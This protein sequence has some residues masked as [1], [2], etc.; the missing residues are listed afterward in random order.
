MP[1]KQIL[2]QDK[3]VSILQNA[4][5][6]QRIPH[7][8]IFAGNDGIGKF[9]TA[10]QW[11][12][13]LLCE[14][15]VLENGFYDCCSTCKS[16]Q[17]VDADSHPDFIHIYKELLEFT[18]EGKNR[19]PPLELP[20]DVIREFLVQ[21]APKKPFHSK[22]KI[23]V[24]TEAEKLN[25]SSQN[26]L[27]K[28]L[29][30]PPGYCSII[31]I[32]NALDKL[33]PTTKSRCQTIRFG[34]VDRSVIADKLKNFDLDTETSDFFARFSKGS[35]GTALFLAKLQAAGAEI[36]N[37]KRQIIETVASLKLEFA[38]K[39][40]S[41]FLLVAKK[42]AKSWSKISTQTSA[43]DIERKSKKLIIN[44]IISALS[45][46]VK[47]NLRQTEL[48][49]NADQTN[50]IAKL[51]ASFNSETASYAIEKAAENISW[52]DANVNEKLI[53]EHLLLNLCVCVRM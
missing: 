45:D 51:A 17:L 5:K 19:Q 47:L 8:Y 28:T 37:T 16:C 1:L 4:Y 31:L 29:E 36:Y 25:P 38:L 41:D 32:C 33:L 44:I 12:K 48:I 9:S 14:N 40:A 15:P 7:A 21:Q 42:I 22:R 2:C 6:A 27:L 24:I 52:I 49:I 23:F 10:K 39:A 30:E 11:A 53:F 50:S 43:K 26:A 3:A 35:I 46:C 13:L 34:P 20:I 18:K